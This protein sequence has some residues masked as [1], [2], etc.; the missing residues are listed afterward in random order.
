MFWYT[1]LKCIPM[2]LVCIWLIWSVQFKS[3]LCHTFMNTQVGP[4]LYNHQLWNFKLG[5]MNCERQLNALIVAILTAFFIRILLTHAHRIPL[6]SALHF[7]AT[8]IIYITDVKTLAFAGRKLRPCKSG[9]SFNI[10]EGLGLL[11]LADISLILINPSPSSVKCSFCLYCLQFFYISGQRNREDPE[12]D[13]HRILQECGRI[14]T[15]KA[16]EVS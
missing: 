5:D 12:I 14:Q 8:Q 16:A 4:Y 15:R 6:S 11:K 3:L 13:E 1:F 10:N 2:A 7:L 9:Q